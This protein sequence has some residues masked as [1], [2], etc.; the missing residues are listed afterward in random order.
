MF[1]A[2]KSKQTILPHYPI[3]MIRVIKIFKFKRN[4]VTKRE[5]DDRYEEERSRKRL[6]ES[7]SRVGGCGIG[8]QF[9]EKGRNY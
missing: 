8:A 5:R 4:R 7:N 1:L 3:I 6:G 2:Y 9:T